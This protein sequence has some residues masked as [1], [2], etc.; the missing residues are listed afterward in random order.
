[1]R[2]RESRIEENFGK[3]SVICCI[4]KGLFNDVTVQ[5]SLTGVPINLMG[6]GLPTT[7]VLEQIHVHWEAEHTIDGVRDAMELHFVHYDKEFANATSASKYPNGIAVVAVLFELSN[8]N[9][10]DLKTI[11]KAVELTSNWVGPNTAMIQSKVVPALLLPK[12]RTTFYRYEGSLTTPGCQE[13]VIWT[14]LT[15]KLTVSESQLNIL[16][17]VESSH[18]DLKFNHRPVQ[19]LGMRDVYHH[20][21]GYSSSPSLISNLPVTIFIIFIARIMT[22]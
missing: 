11:L 2:E 3:G 5:I 1:M 8:K 6:G 16:K 13:S 12:D 19:E 21:E 22:T 4:L 15:E 20:M 9:N 10:E 7:Y 17:R 14:V 18:G